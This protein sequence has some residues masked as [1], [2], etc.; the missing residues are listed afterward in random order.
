MSKHYFS[1][2]LVFALLTCAV[3]PCAV[4][5]ETP[6]IGF[7]PLSPEFLKWQQ[8]H[9]ANRNDT[10]SGSSGNTGTPYS[11]GYI[12]DPIDLSHL[13]YNPPK[14]QTRD[15]D[16]DTLPV[17]YDLR[18]YS[19]VPAI[20]NQSPFGTCWAHAA[21]GAMESSYLTQG[22]TSL[23][24][25]PDLSELHMAWFV[26]K[27]PEP[28]HSYTVGTTSSY[29]SGVLG[30]GGNATRSTAYLTRFAGPVYESAMPYSTAG[31]KS[32][33]GD[34][35]VSEF[36]GDKKPSA[37]FP[38]GLRLLDRYDLGVV[39]SSNRALVKQMIMQ[40]GAV[41][42][43]YYAGAG[44]TSPAGSTTAYFDNSQGTST[45]HAVLLVGWDDN[46]SRENFSTDDNARPSAKGAWLVR[47]SWGSSW[48]DEGYFYMSYE[49]YIAR[50]TAYFAGEYDSDTRYYGYDDL[51]PVG[52]LGY[53][54]NNPAFAAN[55]FR[56]SFDEQ[57]KS[58]A[59]YT[60][61]NNCSYD[62][63][64][65]DLGTSTP[66]SPVTGNPE[67]VLSGNL[68]YA[69]YHT[70][71]LNT[72][73]DISADHFFSVI[74]KLVTSEGHPL[75]GEIVQSGYT[76]SA[77]I[78]AG[79]SYFSG[80]LT[81]SWTDGSTYSTPSNFCIK[82]FTTAIAD[83]VKIDSSA[84]PDSVFMAYVQTLDTDGN[85]YLNDSEIAAV[86]EMHLG[87]RGISD[88]TGIEYFTALVTLSVESNNLTTL[89]ISK[90]TA[91]QILDC[92]NNQLAALD[93]SKNT[94]LKSLSISGTNTITQIDISNNPRL[95]KDNVKANDGVI[96]IEGP[97]F[98]YHSLILDGQIGV[99]FFMYIP[100]TL[101]GS[102]DCCM[103]F[104]VS[105]DKSNA[106]QTFDPEFTLTQDGGT[107]YGFRCYINS[108]QMA[109]NIHAVFTCGETVRTEDYSAAKYLASD[110]SSYSAA[111]QALIS[112]IR[113]YGHFSQI[114]LDEVHDW[115]T[116]REYAAID[117]DTVYSATDISDTKTA[118]ANYAFVNNNTKDSGIKEVNYNLNLD[119]STAVNI[120][121]TV[122]GDYTGNVGAYLP[123]GTANL[124]VKQSDG[125]YKATFSNIAGHELGNTITLTVTAGKDFTLKFSALSYVN[126]VL[127]LHS[128][129]TN[130]CNAVVALYRYY[131]TNIAYRNE[132]NSNYQ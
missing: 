116:G 126:T 27:D 86:T 45:N 39:D 92:Q 74:T 68:P 43:S 81:G 60:N 104:D 110:F 97:R 54:S 82:A 128:E 98:A 109:N 99:N 129:N 55:I 59:F 130:L 93:V 108:I 6:Q 132:Q 7:A 84:F 65:V 127:K 114:M 61:D 17:S 37:Y 19:R 26:Y 112:A 72:P 31:T 47:N 41:Q 50:G 70:F 8:E 38:I 1:A 103:S 131:T 21:L 102:K 51:G 18:K 101:A 40:Y 52:S 48:G 85:G 57:L 83:G 35:L 123:G 5:A 120:L 105:G 75:V 46:F 4:R 77:V 69:G 94:A 78:N 56:T 96:I 89:D 67:P 13:K 32:A 20:R 125:T 71:F 49:Q 34:Q 124:A 88:L 29:G 14:I 66:S 118:A 87:G 106:I 113:D 107:Y 79:E 12:P 64:I 16:G 80:S 117:S 73:V 115:E 36:V 90:N 9:S 2:L 23:G 53:G 25:E 3:F 111:T 22:L 44:A 33:S 100:D 121:L 63:Y 42:I 24:N 58:I 119:S 122:S 76:D 10:S 95:T 11:T 30:K 15:L 62:V 91:L 28:G